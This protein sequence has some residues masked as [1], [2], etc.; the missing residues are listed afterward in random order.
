MD[1]FVCVRPTGKPMSPAAGEYARRTLDQFAKNFAK[2]FRGDVP[3]KD[4]RAVSEADIAQRN[5]ILFGDPGS[6]SVIARVL[7]KLPVHWTADTITLAGK[8]FSAAEHV[9]ALIYPNP[10][11]PS[12]YVVINS[13]HTFGEADLR[14]PMRSSIRAVAIMLL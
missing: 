4:D 9:P 6:N 12:R 10:L 5:L 14:V 3:I 8:K 1:A 11:N 2:Y 13:G 7:S